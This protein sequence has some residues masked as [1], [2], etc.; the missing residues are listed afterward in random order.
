MS[1]VVWM[2]DKGL[3]VPESQEFA[4][5]D[6]EAY[7]ERLEQSEQARRTCAP[8]SFHASLCHSIFCFPF[9]LCFTSRLRSRTLSVSAWTFAAAQLS[10]AL[11]IRVFMFVRGCLLELSNGGHGRCVQRQPILDTTIET[12]PP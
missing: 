10:F 11:L 8:A 1:G 12:M 7:R 4:A 2:P 3:A 6:A 5:G 9:S